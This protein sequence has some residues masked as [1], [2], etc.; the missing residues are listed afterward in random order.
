MRIAVVTVTR[1]GREMGA[2]VRAVLEEHLVHVYAKEDFLSEGDK[3]LHLPL[4]RF[5]GELLKK[6]DALVFVTAMGVAVRTLAGHLRG[7]FE[8]PRVVVLDEVG[9]HVVSLLSGHRGANE[10]AKT[11]AS[12][13]GCEAVIT[14]STDVQKKTC[15]EY[16]ASR[17][18]LALEKDGGL[19][20]LNAAI[21]NDEIVDVYSEIDLGGELPSGFS[22]RP[23]EDLINNVKPKIVITNKLIKTE[24]PTVVMRPKNLIVGVGAR[25]GTPKE[26]ILRAIKK[27]FEGEKLSL[28]SLKALATIEVRAREGGFVEAASSL[29]VP[30]IA[31]SPQEIKKVENEYSSSE[32]VREMIGVGAV[33]EPCA[34][35]AGNN[36]SLITGKK[37]LGGITV[38]VAVEKKKGRVYIVGL[39]PGSRE[40]L[41]PRAKNVLRGVDVVVGYKGYLEYIREYLVGKEVISRGMG[42]EVE[43]AKIAL[44][45]ANQGK[46]VAVVSS[47]DPGIYAMASVVLECASK[48]SLNHGVEVVPGVTAASAAAASLGAPLGHDF[49]VISLSDLLTPW[50][51]IEK[52]LRAAAKGDFCIVLYNPRSRGRRGHLRRAVDV[53]KEHM[54]PSTPVGIVKNAMRDGE[55]VIVTTLNELPEERVDMLS[56]VIIGNS[57]SFIHHSW[58]IT[59]RGYRGI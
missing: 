6:Y 28:K 8:D 32:F 40:H 27:V 44:E 26:D 36:A 7:K 10:L 41:T 2:R 3:E 15:V 49:A 19:K 42:G 57:E 29:D 5:V 23:W 31:I 18:G 37:R 17:L 48:A 50:E 16:L 43:R 39:G 4:R 24:A 54:K 46:D 34:V 58:I 38:A 13:L 59:P 9:G 51:V 53:L 20:E 30:L 35:L 21:A 22:L 14:T 47:G 1:G 56:I 55:E 12:R 33:C 52:R 45:M 11:I 25:R